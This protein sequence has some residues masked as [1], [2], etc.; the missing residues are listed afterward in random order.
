MWQALYP[1][2]EAHNVWQRESII[3]KQFQSNPS[4]HLPD[5]YALPRDHQV[6]SQQMLSPC[7][8]LPWLLDKYRR[9]VCCITGVP[10]EMIEG[11]GVGHETVRKTIA[12]GRLFSTNM[13]EICRHLQALLK[14][15]YREI[16]KKDSNVD[17]LLVPMPRLEVETI[18]D[19]KVLFEIGALTP[20]MSI[21]LSR[22]LL[23]EEPGAKRKKQKDDKE[24]RPVRPADT[25][26]E[27]WDN[28]GQTGGGIQG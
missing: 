26:R 2:F 3:R 14:Q 19:F 12:S 10:F 13:H 8:D 4:T 11:R 22:I 20:D 28:K 17:F 7:E 21:R 27:A 25:I 1:P 5:V 24:E 6:A 18:A 23:G 16:Y 9:D 15:V